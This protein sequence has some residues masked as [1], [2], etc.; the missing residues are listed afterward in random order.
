MQPRMQH[1]WYT[2]SRRRSATVLDNWKHNHDL[3]LISSES[4]SIVLCWL[5]F[6]RKQALLN[7]G[8]IRVMLEFSFY[9][10]I[11]TWRKFNPKQ[12]ATVTLLKLNYLYSINSWEVCKITFSGVIN[13]RLQSN[14]SNTG[15]EWTTFQHVNFFRRAAFEPEGFCIFL[16]SPP[17]YFLYGCVRVTPC[18]ICATT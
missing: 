10:N 6:V 17:S 8:N 11:C 9:G 3:E 2:T 1:H 16:P 4:K 14:P 15:P 13:S 18:Y 12:W 5:L 7:L